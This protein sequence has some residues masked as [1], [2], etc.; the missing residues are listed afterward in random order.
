MRID[1]WKSKAEQSQS[2]QNEDLQ[3]KSLMPFA[4]N[5]RQ[6]MP[7][8]L[9]YNLID[10]I[11][12]VD[13]TGRMIRDD[14]RGAISDAA[15]PI[16]QRLDISTKHWIELTTKFEQRFKGI[17]GSAQSI[18]ALCAHF[19]LSRTINRGNSQLLYG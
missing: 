17:A 10:Y 4:G 15:P 13:W 16:L 8:G 12:F 14:K 1:Y 6:P 11:E 2:G 7:K 19:G 9:I 18:R 3:P 5:L